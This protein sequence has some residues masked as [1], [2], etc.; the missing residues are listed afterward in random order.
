M[1]PFYVEKMDSCEFTVARTE[2]LDALRVAQCILDKRAGP[3]GSALQ[4]SLDKTGTMSLLMTDGAIFIKTLVTLRS[5]SIIDEQIY[6]SITLLYDLI[7]RLDVPEIRF[8][9]SEKS[10]KVMY[11]DGDFVLTR[12]NLVSRDFSAVG[13]HA[14]FTV[15]AA[16]LSETLKL[17]KF[18]MAADDIRDQF[19]GVSLSLSR[20]KMTL[21]STDGIRMSLAELP[22]ECSLELRGIW[23]RK[24]VEA[25]CSISQDGDAK[26]EMYER[27]VKCSIGKSTIISPLINAKLLDYSSIITGDE[28]NKVSIVTD[29]QYMVKK[30]DRMMIL[31][32]SDGGVLLDICDTPTISCSNKQQSDKGLEKLDQIEHSGGDVKFYVNASVLLGFVRNMKGKVELLFYR[33]NN[34]VILRKYNEAYPMYLTKAMIT[35]NP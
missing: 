35:R 27:Q 18:T 14:S 6:L 22:I 8:L 20:G 2:I 11:E 31:S 25:L 17:L 24:F 7:R 4:I 19:K 9:V 29:A 33:S 13:D 26:F 15:N 30:L 21:W 34:N 28:D 16:H 1:V 32:E 10:V 23:P 12:I 3:E 5:N